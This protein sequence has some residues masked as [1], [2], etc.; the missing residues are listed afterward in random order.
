MPF[1]PIPPVIVTQQVGSNA[2]NSSTTGVLNTAIGA[3]SLTDNTTGYSNTA[4]G[5]QSLNSNTSG[6]GNAAF[7]LSS[8]YYNTTGF[9]NTAVGTG[10]CSNGTTFSN[11]TGLGY[12]ASPTASN[13]VRIGNNASYLHRWLRQ[14]DQCI[15]MVGLKRMFRKMSLDWNSSKNLGRLRTNWI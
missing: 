11:S 13:T 6:Y 14:L 2:L 10:S 9:N 5:M 15:V 3:Y 1:I 12:N 8:L 4:N 7:G